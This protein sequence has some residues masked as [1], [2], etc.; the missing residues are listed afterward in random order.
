M[1][2]IPIVALAI[3]LLSLK[4]AA[5]EADFR[6][7]LAAGGKHRF[8]LPLGFDLPDG[9]LALAV[10]VEPA[11]SP[12]DE[13]EDNLESLQ[14]PTAPSAGAESVKDATHSI[15]DLCNALLTS[16]EDNDLPVPFF[17]NLIWQESRLQLNAVSSVGALGIAQFMPEVAV[18]VGLHDP[19]D[20]RQAIP[21]SARFL[22]T[23][24]DHFGNLG[25]V[26]AAYNAGA[27]RVTEWLEHRRALP[28][29]T[30]TYVLRVTGRSAEAWRKAPVA[31]SQ[32][33]FVQPLPC[34]KLPAFAEL[35]QAQQ[36]AAAVMQRPQ[37]EELAAEVAQMDPA[38]DSDA[39]A[40]AAAHKGAAR[41]RHRS[42]QKKVPVRHHV[43]VE[44]K[45]IR[46]NPH[47]GTAGRV[48]PGKRGG[49]HEAARRARPHEKHKLA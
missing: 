42:E 49:R 23:L 8:T 21:A 38:K 36:Q 30:Q 20:P 10:P 31:D 26:A 16:A 28:R 22:R 17:A 13:G 7:A 39:L 44:R 4:G 25:F 11:E 43:A 35:E 12:H 40:P 6:E 41:G 1:R 47:T 45:E 33:A 37:P 3:L 5:A 15:D 9:R 34:R 32:L 2:P 24:R 19:F 29:Q 46:R 14:P 18:E 27:H 48:A